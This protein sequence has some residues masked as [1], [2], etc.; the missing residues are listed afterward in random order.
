M[1]VGIGTDITS[2]KR[3]SAVYDKYKDRFVQRI[4][5][6]KEINS[7]NKRK[8]KVHYLA[9]RF[10][11]KEAVAKALGTGIKRGV[12]WRNIAVLNQISGA[13]FIILY[14]EALARYEQLG[15]KSSHISISDEQE[16]A[17][18]FVVLSSDESV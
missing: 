5:T 10:A 11:A 1:I 15:A 14:D 17:I 13:P 6:R 16:Y 18:A 3:I 2:V 4:L 7:Y 9:K 8:N 12:F